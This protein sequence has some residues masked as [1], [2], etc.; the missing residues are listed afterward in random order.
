MDEI[1]P[2]RTSIFCLTILCAGLASTVNAAEPKPERTARPTSFKELIDVAVAQDD[3]PQPVK[4]S[5]GAKADRTADVSPVSFKELID[6]P[7]SPDDP[8]QAVKSPHGSK[9][10]RAA[11]L[12]RLDQYSLMRQ[13]ADEAHAKSWSCVECHKNCGDMHKPNTL[14]LGCVDCHGGNASTNNKWQSHVQ[15]RFPDVWASTGNPVRSYTVLNHECPDFIRFVNPGDLRIAHLSCGTAG[16]H[17]RETL[18]VKKSMMTHGCML[19]GAALY[20]NGAIPN[21]RSSYGESY[22][23]NGNPQRLQTV[24]AP[25]EWEMKHKGVVPFLDPLPRFEI[26]HP[27]NVLRIFERGGRFRTDV[28]IPTRDEEPGRPRTRGRGYAG[29]S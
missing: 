1:M 27:G 15:P 6:V 16:C 17:P 10:D 29:A 21:K 13:S 19:W 7:P 24:P 22:S 28:G 11:D 9:A 12:S 25:T 14:N 26:S 2:L 8:P 23:M 20:N 3:S 5:R 18:E 4:A